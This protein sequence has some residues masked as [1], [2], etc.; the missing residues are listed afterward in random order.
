M[1]RAF[2]EFMTVPCV[3]VAVFALLAVL[4]ILM[5]ASQDATMAAGR[6]IISNHVFR[7]ESGTQDLLDTLLAGLLTLI[8]ITF[9]ILLLAV[10]Q[11]ASSL[12]NQVYDQFLRRTTNQ[13]FL[14]YA[15]GLAL[16]TLVVRS[17]VG[18]G[19]NPVYSASLAVILTMIG[20]TLLIVLIYGTIYQM[21]PIVIIE[22][23][24]DHTLAARKRQQAL[25]ANTRRESECDAPVQI[26]IR[27]GDGG[28]LQDVRLDRLPPE[29][30][31]AQDVEIEIAASIGTY[32]AR[33]DTVATIKADD[34]ARARAFLPAVTAALRIESDRDLGA[35]P[36]WGIVELES[37]AWT[38]VSSA[39]STPEPPRMVIHALRDMLVQWT[40]GHQ[41]D[42]GK[43]EA[44]PWPL[45]Y[46]DDLHL[47]VLDAIATIAAGAN[48]SLQHVVMAEAL[49]ALS[50]L[51]ESTCA[52]LQPAICDVARRVVPALKPLILTRSLERALR[53]LIKTLEKQGRQDIADELA[54]ALNKKS[55]CNEL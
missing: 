11:T 30:R 50:L 36:A 10:Q 9:S 18:K 46:R 15:V 26:A 22:A 3:V 53:Q 43:N 54:T 8:S 38:T 40:D 6:R 1:R 55:H 41:P 35:D 31:K 23:M 42:R 7:S 32:F 21:R 12:S 39:K 52:A 14:G 33:R 5:D 49:Q 13:I 45:V 37:M 28:F 16:E 20:L 27:V 4:T 19:F 17:V 48:E 34:P 29:L 24:H 44:E 51:M 25:I 47:Q 2:D